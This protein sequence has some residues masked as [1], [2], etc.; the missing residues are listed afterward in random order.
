[1]I[2]LVEC[3][4]EKLSKTRLFEMA[5]QRR[6]YMKT[7]FDLRL[8]L[9]EN[10]ALIRYCTLQES[11]EEYHNLID[12][13]Q[14][15]NHWE[16]ELR[17]HISNLYNMKLDVDKTQATEQELIEYSEFKNIDN[18]KEI[19]EFK[20]DVEG[21]LNDAAKDIIDEIAKDFV[22][23]GLDELIEIICKK[24]LSVNEIK[25]YLSDI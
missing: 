10:W 9:V 17:A 21:I 24:K 25:E 13:S 22:E 5:F 2:K 23:Y 7:L 20:F 1:M 12:V 3:I 15:R 18:I 8:Q 11:N 19:I 14:T 6:V 16:K 4:V